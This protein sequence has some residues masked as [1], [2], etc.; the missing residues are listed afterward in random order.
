MNICLVGKSKEQILDEF[1][2]V[3]KNGTSKD[4]RIFVQEAKHRGITYDELCEYKR[5]KEKGE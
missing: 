2:M 5:Q 1:I 3:C 4:S